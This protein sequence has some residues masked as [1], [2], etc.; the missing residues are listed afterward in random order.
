MFWR[1]TRPWDQSTV[2]VGSG[3]CLIHLDHKAPRARQSTSRGATLCISTFLTAAKSSSPIQSG[4]TGEADQSSGTPQCRERSSGGAESRRRRTPMLEPRS[5]WMLQ[6]SHL[7]SAQPECAATA[8]GQF[9]RQAGLHGW[10]ENGSTRSSP[11]RQTKRLSRLQISVAPFSRPI[12][13][14]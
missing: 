5:T 7:R 4:V 6:E 13:A 9:T 10:F 8:Q 3:I 14:I 1:K 2:G 11:G 12:S